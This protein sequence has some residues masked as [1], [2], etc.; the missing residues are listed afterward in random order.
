LTEVKK[1]LPWAILLLVLFFIVRNPAGAATTAKEIGSGLGTIA[2]GIGRFFSN[3][4]GA[5]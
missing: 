2:D 5:K 4:V 3:L 1:I